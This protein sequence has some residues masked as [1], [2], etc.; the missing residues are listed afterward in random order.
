MENKYRELSSL[1]ALRNLSG[2]FNF[3]VPENVLRRFFF[4]PTDTS[5][6]FW[7]HSDRFFVSLFTTFWLLVDIDVGV[8]VGVDDDVDVDVGVAV[9]GIV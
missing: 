1:S 9:T 2:N 5:E 8:D 6:K 3:L 4:S 7:S